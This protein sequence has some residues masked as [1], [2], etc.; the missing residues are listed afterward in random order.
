MNFVT[1]KRACHREQR[2]SGMVFDPTLFD[3]YR[4]DN[5]LDIYKAWRYVGLM[6]PDLMKL[7]N[8][9]AQITP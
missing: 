9:A 2:E 3:Q 5:R 8:R 4:E 1:E 7:V 6:E